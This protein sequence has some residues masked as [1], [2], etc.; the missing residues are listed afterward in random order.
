MTSPSSAPPSNAPRQPFKPARFPSRRTLRLILLAPLLALIA[1]SGLMA[2]TIWYLTVSEET[3]REQALMRDVD[4]T[5]RLMRERLQRRQTELTG[6]AAEFAKAPSTRQLRELSNGFFAKNQDVVFLAW[7]DQKMTVRGVMTSQGIPSQSFDPIGRPLSRQESVTAFEFAASSRQPSYSL[8]FGATDADVEVDLHVPILSQG[9]AQ[10]TL[11]AT[12]SLPSLLI[13]SVPSEISDRVAFSLVN[14]EGRPLANT[15]NPES[16][17]DKPFYEVTLEPLGRSVRLRG[18][19][20]LPFNSLYNDVITTLIAGL[21][22]LA[23]ASQI[24]IWRNTRRRLGAEVELAE[25]TAFR[26]AMENSMST[27]MRVIDLK[28]RI[29][30]VNPA[31]C[32]MV[33][34]SQEELVGQDPP[35]PYW[36]TES[37]DQLQGNLRR[38]LSGES[39][40]SGL[41]IHIMRKDGSR[42]IVR[43]YTSPL[44]DQSG[45]QTG[46]MTSVTDI[47]E[48]ARIRQEL[49]NAQERFITVLQALDAAVSVA[50]APPQD[51]LLFANQAY[52]KWFGHSL[53]DGHRALS[54]ANRGPWADVRDVYSESVQR[55]FEVRLRSIQWVDGRVVELMVA[56]DITQERAS[57][58]AQREQH[59]RLQQT[60]RLV[61]M[62]EMASSL[63][64]ELNQPLTAIANYTSGAAARLRTANQ[65]NTPVPIEDLIELLQK[66][67]KQAERAGQVIRRIRSF[68]KRSDPNRRW[69]DAKAIVADA[70]ELAEIDARERGLE[71]KQDLDPEL[72]ILHVDQILIEQV[73][74]NLIKNGLEAMKDTRD[75]TL[76]VIVN[77]S[78]QSVMFSVVDRG[79]GV[80]Q[81]IRDRLFDSFYTTKTDGMGM[82]LNI[83]RS[84]IE[85]HHGRL[86][87]EDNPEGGCTFRFTLPLSPP[88]DAA[89]PQPKEDRAR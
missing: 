57:E 21:I 82:G 85:S 67:A 8:P 60:S 13:S 51:E 26:R 71:I 34:F 63:A 64:H 80:P 74:L 35:F 45:Q 70:I 58:Q 79:H 23:V 27:G 33:G 2:A 5:Q 87:F 78:D 65:Q 17:L 42:L 11:V 59:A 73:L 31:F 32:R 4:S 53:I 15:R 44:I 89:P 28:G 54:A 52:K 14:A 66:T 30:Y 50:T 37:K 69:V 10:G 68:V 88:K 48:Q 75:R 3:Q 56:T 20:Y 12:I 22:S 16:M 1:L 83:C 62:G 61:T 40:P 29:T 9:A 41:P 77:R 6:I 39:P 24:L 7:L 25:E 36:P 47:S 19:S 38:M 81:A 84:I 55:W 86:W 43:M 49:A 46:W 18:Y 76:Q 72:P